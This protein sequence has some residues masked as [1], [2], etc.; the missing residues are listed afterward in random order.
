MHIYQF[1]LTLIAFLALLNHSHGEGSNNNIISL[2][3]SFRLNQ[4]N[5]LNINN[6]ALTTRQ[7]LAVSKYVFET[8]EDITSFAPETFF[9]AIYDLES[10]RVYL[11]PSE[12]A[13]IFNQTGQVEELPPEMTNVRNGGHM[14]LLSA[15]LK[16]LNLDQNHAQRFRGG[17]VLLTGEG[18]MIVTYKS[19]STNRLGV[20]GNEM[21]FEHRVAF[22]F[23][24]EEQFGLVYEEMDDFSDRIDPAEFIRIINQ[25]N[26]IF[27]KKNLVNINSQFKKFITNKKNYEINK[28]SKKIN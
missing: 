7:S 6:F 16:K 4:N 21:E 26:Y 27:D 12:G 19:A 18:K 15:V 23:A 9:H 13:R 1:V 5:S 28:T 8:A 14:Q 24:I 25:Y 11:S 10:G 17:G 3:N 20:N 22:V 2:I